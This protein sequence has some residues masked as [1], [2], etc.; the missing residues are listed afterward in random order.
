M[1]SRNNNSPSRSAKLSGQ[2]DTSAGHPPPE[3]RITTKERL[4][5][6]VVALFEFCSVLIGLPLIIF[7]EL[8]SWIHG[9]IGVN[10]NRLQGKVVI[11]KTRN[12]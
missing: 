8:A 1:K 12:I 6:V 4:S 9:F 10:S 3:I 5:K 7:N 11:I 2:N